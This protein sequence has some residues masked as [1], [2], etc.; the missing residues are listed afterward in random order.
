L[1]VV[2]A[3]VEVERRDDMDLSPFN[4]GESLQVTASASLVDDDNVVVDERAV[5]L[6]LED[7]LDSKRDNKLLDIFFF[8]VLLC[9]DLGTILLSAAAIRAPSSVQGKLIGLGG[10]FDANFPSK[11]ARSSY[12]LVLKLSRGG[13]LLVATLPTGA[14]AL[15]PIAPYEIVGGLPIIHPC[16]F[17]SAACAV[18]ITVEGTY[19][20]HL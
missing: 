11:S 16:T 15:Y 5:E 17:H 14:L 13:E 7:P 20:S 6:R 18:L 2:V 10:E 12:S 8:V 1:V 4:F 9:R 3:V 19:F